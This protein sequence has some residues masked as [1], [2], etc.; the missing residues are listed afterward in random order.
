MAIYVR[1]S[2]INAVLLSAIIILRFSISHEHIISRFSGIIKS[3]SKI[4]FM[5][6]LNK[7]KFTIIAAKI[8]V[9]DAFTFV[10]L[11][12]REYKICLRAKGIFH[13][14]KTVAKN[15]KPAS[16]AKPVFSARCKSRGSS[17]S[18]CFF[19]ERSILTPINCLC[20]INIW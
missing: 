6:S 8:P 19:R 20:I 18:I 17:K 16:R 13:P 3:F 1:L 5:F 4:L 15:K 9:H 7:K 10:H 11:R 12:E 14:G 2:S